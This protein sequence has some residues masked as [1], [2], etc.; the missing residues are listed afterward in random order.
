MDER[1]DGRMDGWDAG[2]GGSMTRRASITWAGARSCIYNDSTQLS[3][4]QT[5]T[6]NNE[7][8]HEW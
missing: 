7:R 5:L 1:V 4:K 3:V 2:D 8:G 6:L